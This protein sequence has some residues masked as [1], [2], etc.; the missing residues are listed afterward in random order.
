[1]ATNSTSV[2]S[3]QL[4]LSAINIVEPPFYQNDEWRCWILYLVFVVKIVWLD[5]GLT[6]AQTRTALSYVKSSES[7]EIIKNMKVIVDECAIRHAANVNVVESND[8]SSSLLFEDER[9]E[10]VETDKAARN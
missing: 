5:L 10:T 9:T 1:M 8:F 3:H 6:S 2:H 4:N 7:I